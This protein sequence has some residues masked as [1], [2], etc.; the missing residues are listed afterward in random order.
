[1]NALARL[2]P[3]C[4]V[5]G[6]LFVSNIGDAC[7]CLEVNSPSA[8]YKHAAAVVVGQV[9]SLKQQRDDVDGADVTLEV[10][11]AWKANVPARLHLTT[12]T[13][14][15]FAFAAGG[16]YLLF[17]QQVSDDTYTTGRCMGNRELAKASS[18]LSWLKANGKAAEVVER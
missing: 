7:R 12:G 11:R 18:F 3:T 1:M 2:L 5:G 14:C 15:A 13:T 6:I 10:T 16:S 9:E 4:L 8:A 17:L